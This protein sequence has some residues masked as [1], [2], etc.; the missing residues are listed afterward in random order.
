MCFKYMIERW[1]PAGH[2]L[3]FLGVNFLMSGLHSYR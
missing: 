3:T 1:Y 2:P